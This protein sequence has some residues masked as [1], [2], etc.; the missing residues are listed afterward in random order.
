MPELIFQFVSSMTKTL[1]ASILQYNKASE[2]FSAVCHP[3][4][5][6]STGYPF[7]EI[8]SFFKKKKRK[9]QKQ[10]SHYRFSWKTAFPSNIWEMLQP[11]V[12]KN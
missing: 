11:R 12:N 1:T 3:A 10:W 5:P 7:L 9:E 8:I 6:A 4:A 2:I